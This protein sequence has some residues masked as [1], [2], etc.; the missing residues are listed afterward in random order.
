MATIIDFSSA[1]PSAQAIK[2]AG[3]SGAILYI[4]PPRAGWMGAKPA[5]RKIVQEYQ[6]AGLELAFVWQFGAGSRATSDVMR[7]A[8]G[9]ELDARS[10]DEQLKAIGCEGW[11]VYFSVDFDISLADW[12]NTARDYFIAAGKVLGRDRVGIY[13]HSRVVHWAG[14]ENKVVAEV[15]PGRFLGWI[16]RSW[17]STLPDGS[18][19]GASYSTLYQRV[20]DTKSNPGPVVGGVVVDVNDIRHEYWGQRPP[21]RQPG[22]TPSVPE[23][24]PVAPPIQKHPGWTGDPTWLAPALRAFGVDVVEDPGWDKWGNGDFKSIWGVVAHHTGSNNTTTGIIRFGHSAL[25]GLLSQV[26]LSRSGRATLVGIG[27]AWHAGV[28]DWPGLPKNNANYHTIGIEAQSDGT[29][30]WPA[31]Q[32]DAYYR[33]CAAICWVLGVNADR[34]IAHHEWGA[35]QG[36]WDP[37]AGN[38]RSGV[39]MDMTP[40]RKNVQ[41]YIDNPPFEK[42]FEDIMTDF[43]HIDRKYP[44]RVEGSDWKGRPIDALFNADAHAFTARVNTVQILEELRVNNELTRESNELTKQNSMRIARLEKALGVDPSINPNTKEN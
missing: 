12:N 41:H 31:E 15:A 10:A 20:V 26:H 13:G 24:K 16:T 43:D 2:S 36:K 6:D 1:F 11:P 22:A 38:G 37:G 33:I 27:V 17:G 42:E 32:M 21:G 4:S 30:P 34:V 23:R 29:S 14:P 9:G 5:T 35:I 8:R 39:K 40:F 19:R 3:H 44:S 7:G 25:K 28:G 18:G